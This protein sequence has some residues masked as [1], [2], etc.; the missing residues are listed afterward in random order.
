MLGDFFKMNF[1]LYNDEINILTHQQ[2]KTKL[3]KPVTEKK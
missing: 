3:R 2:L 1:G